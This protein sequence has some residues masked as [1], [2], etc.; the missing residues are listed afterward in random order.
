[1]SSHNVEAIPLMQQG[2]EEDHIL[3]QKHKAHSFNQPRSSLRSRLIRALPYLACLVALLSFTLNTLIFARPSQKPK[4]DV[5]NGSVV[6]SLRK[7]SLYLGIDR[8]PEIKEML[9]LESL[10]AQGHATATGSLPT[11]THAHGGSAVHDTSE[12]PARSVN[13]ARV[14]SRYPDL[15][16]PQ[17]GWVVLSEFDRTIL[18]LHSGSQSSRCILTSAFPGRRSLGDRLLTIEIDDSTTRVARIQAR[19]LSNS[20][21]SVDFS[22][23]TW[24]SRSSLSHLIGELE[25]DFGRNSSTSEFACGGSELLVELACLGNGCGVE[26]KYLNEDSTSFINLVSK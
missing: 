14:N 12:H 2:E 1:M 17:D 25:V 10:F 26:F 8:V 16:Y 15:I 4:L 11:E 5:F 20:D 19:V 23:L 13:I 3:E 21:S 9:S 18:Q 7:P 6:Q 22:S 24:N